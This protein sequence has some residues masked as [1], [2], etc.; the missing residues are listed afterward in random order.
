MLSG[1]VLFF[2]GGEGAWADVGQYEDFVGT[3]QQKSISRGRG[4]EGTLLLVLK[5]VDIRNE[6]SLS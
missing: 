3:L 1:F 2:L 4:S 6:S 5:R